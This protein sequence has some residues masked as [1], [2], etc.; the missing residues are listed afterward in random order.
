MS[1]RTSETAKYDA[2]VVG[3]GVGGLY[4]IYR[5]RKLGLKVRALKMPATQALDRASQ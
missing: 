1:E 4:A 2:L 3:A 5:L